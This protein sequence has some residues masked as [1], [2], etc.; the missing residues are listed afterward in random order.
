[1]VDH[2]FSSDT[3]AHTRAAYGSQPII[4]QWAAEDVLKP[5]YGLDY[6]GFDYNII[7]LWP[8]PVIQVLE[9]PPVTSE[10]S[11]WFEE[12][13]AEL[14]KALKHQIY[15]ARPAEKACQWCAYKKLCN[16]V[17]Y[18][19]NEKLLGLKGADEEDI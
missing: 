2:K 15:F 18:R 19:V 16:P 17:I 5:K 1:M 9:I 4:Y 8:S 3:W 10:Q 6:A 7:R 11:T 12:Q 13:I 14:A